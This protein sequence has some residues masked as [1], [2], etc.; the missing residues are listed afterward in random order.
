MALILPGIN[1]VWILEKPSLGTYMILL[2]GIIHLMMSN[3]M[4]EIQSEFGFIAKG[5][6]TLYL[7]K[8][9]IACN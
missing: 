8:T 5:K 7:H 4:E 1:M 2:G 3:N 6:I 9:D